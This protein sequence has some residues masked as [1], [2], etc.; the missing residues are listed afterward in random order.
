MHEYWTAGLYCNLKGKFIQ[1]HMENLTLVMLVVSYYN[2]KE[3]LKP[4]K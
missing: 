3:S 2:V 1:T 4:Y